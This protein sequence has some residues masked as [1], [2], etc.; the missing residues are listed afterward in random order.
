MGGTQRTGGYTAARRSPF[1][2]NAPVQGYALNLGPPSRQRL[3]LTSFYPFSDM[4]QTPFR[5][6]MPPQRDNGPP[7]GPHSAVLSQKSLFLPIDRL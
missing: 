2:R 6:Q 3:P 7:L 1:G 4:P 5:R